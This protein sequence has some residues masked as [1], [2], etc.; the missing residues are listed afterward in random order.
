MMQQALP[1]AKAF[2]CDIFSRHTFPPDFVQQH[3]K[4]PLVRQRLSEV[5][6]LYGH[7]RRRRCR[8]QLGSQVLLRLTWRGARAQRLHELG[9]A[10]E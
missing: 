7:A 6:D 2:P 4:G 1:V 3:V 8:Q 9:T 10:T 5:H